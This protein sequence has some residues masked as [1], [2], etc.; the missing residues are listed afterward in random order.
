MC[1]EIP[2]I[3]THTSYAYEPTSFPTTTTLGLLRC[4]T[5]GDMFGIS[6]MASDIPTSLYSTELQA[7]KDTLPMD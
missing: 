5:T 4:E 1:G 2:E 6:F 3:L 7:D